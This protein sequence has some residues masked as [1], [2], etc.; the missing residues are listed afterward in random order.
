M[1]SMQ[2]PVQSG[3]KKDYFEHCFFEIIV[4]IMDNAIEKF[5]NGDDDT[6]SILR[7]V[8]KLLH[9]QAEE[10]FGEWRQ[11]NKNVQEFWEIV[12]KYKDANIAP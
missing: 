7:N 5:R 6:A 3:E 9:E 4:L 10:L 8:S 2:P 12:D 11:T 1:K